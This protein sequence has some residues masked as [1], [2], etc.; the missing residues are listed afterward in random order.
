MASVCFSSAFS[1]LVTLL[2]CG[3]QRFVT[4]K[5]NSKDVHFEG[6]WLWVSFLNVFNTSAQ[7]PHTSHIQYKKLC[8]VRSW[9]SV[10]IAVGGN[11]KWLAL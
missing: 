8:F 3:R 7:I 10:I 1:V 9:I 4:V 11:D 6:V 5:D 2:L